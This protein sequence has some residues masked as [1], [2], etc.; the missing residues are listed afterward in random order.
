MSKRNDGYSIS[1]TSKQPALLGLGVGG[2][3]EANR[4][5]GGRTTPAQRVVVDLYTAAHPYSPTLLKS[6][7][8][9]WFWGRYKIP[10][11]PQRV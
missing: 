8:P 11:S 5:G 6:I 4:R 10:R 7:E 9:G 1:H 3:S 2:V